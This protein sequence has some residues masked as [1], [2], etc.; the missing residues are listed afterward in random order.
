M[1]GR[2]RELKQGDARGNFGADGFGSEFNS[3]RL[4]QFLRLIADRLIDDSLGVKQQGAGE[5]V[6][7]RVKFVMLAKQSLRQGRRTI[8]DSRFLRLVTYGW[9]LRKRCPRPDLDASYEGRV[10]AGQS[11][12]PCREGEDEGV[13][14]VRLQLV[15]LLL[16]PLPFECQ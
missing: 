10:Q 6:E 14:Q 15:L 7:Y 2:R 9:N 12:D 8:H 5:F 1:A 11:E 4:H 16:A 3:R 13:F